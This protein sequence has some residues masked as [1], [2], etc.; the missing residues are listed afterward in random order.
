MQEM[1]GFDGIKAARPA[2]NLATPWSENPRE[3]LVKV[4]M[5][6]AGLPAPLQQVEI[7]S[8]G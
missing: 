4:E 6:Q 1:K 7:S 5:F 8:V 3:S 2:V